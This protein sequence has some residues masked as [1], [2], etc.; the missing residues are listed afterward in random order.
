[1][2]PLRKQVHNIVLGILVIFCSLVLYKPFLD[3]PHLTGSYIS[4]EFYEEVYERENDALSFGNYKGAPIQIQ[5]N[6]NERL[7]SLR[8][9]LA[10]N[11]NE[12]LVFLSQYEAQVYK[13]QKSGSI[14]GAEPIL[15][16]AKSK[17]LFLL[18][19]DPHVQIYNTLGESSSIF[20]LL[21]I[22]KN[23]P[24]SIII[25]LPATFIIFLLMYD[26]KKQ[27]GKKLSSYLG[28]YI[29]ALLSS[30]FVLVLP[31]IAIALQ[32]GIGD[33]FYPIV[34]LNSTD[35]LFSSALKEFS[36]FII[37]Y[38]LVLAVILLIFTQI[39]SISNR[40]FALVIAFSLVVIIAL[41]MI[42]PFKSFFGH[43]KPKSIS[44]EY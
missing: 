19:D 21:Y 4:K 20:Y 25:L 26:T 39:N 2:T 3:S 23:L 7:N 5:K 9:A 6:V 34:T 32:N 10:S 14:V 18:G 37:M 1:M 17:T 35:L 38:A 31:L 12:Y 43:F 29:C 41:V 36:K 16:Q 8:N 30:M 33:I 11:D 13:L 44:W 42:S 28:I 40:Y 15:T 27:E 22:L 24:I